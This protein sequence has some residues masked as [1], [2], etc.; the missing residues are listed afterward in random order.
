MKRLINAI[1]FHIKLI[2]I[3]LIPLAFLV[4][5]SI[6]LISERNNRIEVTGKVV[7]DI[8]KNLVVMNLSSRLHIE[9]RF[10]YAYLV[11]NYSDAQF[12]AAQ[13][14]TNEQLTQLQTLLDTNWLSFTD[15]TMLSSLNQIRKDIL[16]RRIT[17]DEVMLYYSSMQERV[18][19]LNDVN[20]ENI[21]YLGPISD[22]LNS[23]K[24]L[25]QLINYF[26]IL[27]ANVYSLSVDKESARRE[28]DAVQIGYKTF[29][30][31]AKEF[32]AKSPA[33]FINRI[34]HIL[35]S[36]EAVALAETFDYITANK[37]LP[38]DFNAEAWWES[39][40][41]VI[42]NLL[43]Q[44]SS[45]MERTRSKALKIYEDEKKALNQSVAILLII[46]SLIIIIV[47]YTLK[48]ISDLLSQIRQSAEKLALGETNIILPIYTNDSI[49]HLVQSIKTIDRSNTMIAKAADAIGTGDFDLQFSPRSENDV[50]GNAILRMKNDLAEYTKESNEKIWIQTGI[51][52]VSKYYRGE[53]G[54]EQLAS[55][56]LTALA[57][58]V[59]AHQG[60]LY[61]AHED[62][63]L[64]QLGAAYAT[65]SNEHVKRKLQYG[66]TLIG[67]VAKSRK[68]LLLNFSEEADTLIVSGLSSITPSSVIIVPLLYNDVLEGVIELSSIEKFNPHLMRFFDEVGVGIAVALSATKS[69]LRLQELLEETQAQSEELQAQHSEL[70]NINAELEAQAAKLATSE[71]ELKVQQEE[72]LEANRELEE[73]S[74]QLEERNQ[75]IIERNAEIQK[76]A[77]ELELST[78]YKSEFLANM[79]HE[80][81]TPLNSI[82]LLS[83]LLSEN[84]Q[85]NLDEEQIEYAKVIQS[86][87]NGLLALI[88]EILD[89]S[90][91]EAGHMQLE[92]SMV[93]VREAVAELQQLFAPVAK[94]K[95][96][97]LKIEVADE[98]PSLIETDKLRMDQII[99]NLLSNALKF[100][101]KGY[102]ELSVF[103][104]NNM[105]AFSVKDSGIGI[106]QNKQQLIFEA[107]QQADGS[108]RRKFGGT[109]LGLSISR[110]LAR[111]LGG[112]IEL[113]SEVA[114]GSNFTLVIPADKKAA[115][116]VHAKQKQAVQEIKDMAEEDIRSPK[117]PAAPS[118]NDIVE[119]IPPAMEDDRDAIQAG[120]RVILIVE[121]DT[122]FAKALLGYTRSQGYKCV[123]AV[124]GDEGLHL[125]KKLVPTAILLDIKLPVMS[126]WEVME[127]LKAGSQTRHIPVHIMSSM[128][129][130]RESIS[131]GAID[132]INKPLAFEKMEEVFNRLNHLLSNDPKKVLIVEE[133]EK[134]AKALAYFLETVNVSCELTG[135]VGNS[136]HALKKHEVNCVILDMGAAG[137]QSAYETLE[138]IKKNEGLEN[139]PIIIFTGK[140]LS[141]N[142]E[143][144]IRQYADSIVVKT[145][146]SYQRILDEVSIFLHLI[147]DQKNTKP[148]APRK[149]GALS[150]ILKNKKVLIADDDARN[151][152]SLTKPLELQ[153]MQ[154]FHAMDGKEALTALQENPDIDVIL[155]DMMMPLMDGYESIRKIRSF[156]EYKNL[157][158][159]AVTA[160]A[161]AGDREK[162]IQ[163]GASDYISKPVDID[164]LLSLLRVWLYDKTKP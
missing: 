111:L 26:G 57:G 69:R 10:G 148:A 4:Y 142:E 39:S 5:F 15:F 72:L 121:D 74:T 73:R 119:L 54:I 150:N 84:T 52:S 35:T 145:A 93:N 89:L 53:K 106:P 139:L 146:H 11:N 141:P 12:V 16:A 109:G 107:F 36:D 159:I 7:N 82:L 17:A 110:Q 144:K 152:F 55:D 130:R 25:F 87:G 101:S 45:L 163:A 149:L 158:I 14:A 134:H 128:Q 59:N 164:Q 161:M 143:T 22:E 125:A 62:Q 90:K 137:S 19:Y 83:R 99:R 136:I 32:Q 108:T 6:Q 50:L 96:L 102:V 33:D 135:D 58:Y 30:S 23:E 70:E 118:K 46:V 97:Q 120:D 71:E 140:N 129:A 100:T 122:E 98:V 124:R 127:E 160:K 21:A 92:Y 123:V 131:R 24:I 40:G 64:L 20:V 2:L 112:D 156:K 34:N 132:F 151:I 9:R 95:N 113:K 80:L 116:I 114:E 94:E 68:P 115:G 162:C 41:N 27:R 79:S 76:K 85:H 61:F 88:D 67:Q 31:Y 78:K 103:M 47:F 51:T 48:N 18:Q 157:P 81:R 38:P 155:M 42:N 91:I 49:G 60:L 1:P 154:V 13:N 63:E 29:G 153:Q 117:E 147:E 44:Q 77:E 66:E 104:R 105:V 28:Y 8:Q 126:G 75:I 65:E 138:T 133:D 37:S 56:V 43:Q 86:S 3:G